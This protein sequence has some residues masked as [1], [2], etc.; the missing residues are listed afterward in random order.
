MSFF[1][2]IHYNITTIIS[3]FKMLLGS[4]TKV[5]RSPDKLCVHWQTFLFSHKTIA[6]PQETL[7]LLTK[8]LKYKVL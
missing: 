4:L 5:L 2:V 6:F 1:F 7:F 3:P 8:A